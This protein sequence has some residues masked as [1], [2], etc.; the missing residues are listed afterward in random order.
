[1][2][3]K[4]LSYINSKIDFPGERGPSHTDIRFALPNHCLT[5]KTIGLG[6]G[7]IKLLLPLFAQGFDPWPPGGGDV[8]GRKGEERNRRWG[9]GCMAL[10]V[11][12]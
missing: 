3:S 7:N 10:Y 2:C 6:Y 8:D 4:S 9:V 1:M 12:Y 5:P 11:E